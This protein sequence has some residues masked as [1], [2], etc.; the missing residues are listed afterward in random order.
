M[1]GIGLVRFVYI[2]IILSF[3]AILSG[4]ELFLL[5]KVFQGATLVEEVLS[6]RFGYEELLQVNQD[7]VAKLSN[8]MSAYQDPTL[9]TQ[10]L[11]WATAVGF[12]LSLW[13]KKQRI[14]FPDDAERART[15]SGLMGGL[16]LVTAF[17]LPLFMADVGGGVLSILRGQGVLTF[18]DVLN[19]YQFGLHVIGF[20]LIGAVF[21]WLAFLAGQ[22]LPTH[23]TVPWTQGSLASRLMPVVMQFLTQT[24]AVGLDSKVLGAVSGVILTKLWEGS[25]SK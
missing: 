20:A 18:L 3:I 7:F 13:V 24:I 8:G 15:V 22:L 11:L 2:F 12:G 6:R 4:L 25:R 21:A 16:V 10:M 9:Q 23:L 14:G 1:N 19:W 5:P 17:F